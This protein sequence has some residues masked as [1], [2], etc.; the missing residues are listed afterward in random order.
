MKFY[1]NTLN[2]NGSGMKYKRKR[3]FLD[4]ISQMIDDCID[5]GGT[6]FDVQIDSDASCFYDDDD[7]YDE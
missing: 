1:I 6:Y 2:D 3:E 4:E 7:D 5:N